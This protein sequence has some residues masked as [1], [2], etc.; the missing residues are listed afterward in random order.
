MFRSQLYAVFQVPENDIWNDLDGH[1]LMEHVGSD[2][3]VNIHIKRKTMEIIGKVLES[4]TNPH[5]Y[6]I[7]CWSL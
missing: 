5:G 6:A 1:K 4:R 7:P 2:N 3:A